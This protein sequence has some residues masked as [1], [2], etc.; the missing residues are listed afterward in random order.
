MGIKTAYTGY[1]AYDY[2]TPGEDYKY[3][4][5]T[6]K[7]RIPEYL[8]PLTP[9]QEERSLKLARE[10]IVISMHEH[11]IYNPVDLEEYRPYRHAGRQSF[12]Y[13]ALAESYLDCIFDN[14]MNGSCVITSHN[15]WK[16]TDIVHDLGMRLC[17]IA[18]Q[19]FV[20]HCKRVDDIHRA[21]K[22]GKLAWVAC[23]E[24]AMPIENEVDRIDIM[25]GL[26]IR[27]LGLTYSESNAVGSGLKEV[28][29][30][31]LTIFGREV[32]KRMNK[33]GMLI[34]VSHSSPLTAIDAAELS[35]VPICM[36]HAGAKA[37]WNSKRLATDESIKAIAA[38]GGVIGI[39]AAPH[40]TITNNH[41][42]HDI[43]AIMEHFEYVAN[44]VGID[45]VCFGPDTNFGDHAGLH[46]IFAKFLSTGYTKNQ[47][48]D[49]P[50]VDHVKGMEN[51]REASKNIIRWLV[52]HGY[53]DDDIGK[54]AGGNILRVL[55]KV[56]K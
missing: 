36:S 12:A 20:I 43:D 47:E 37:L 10:K 18:H 39:E 17:D 30:A 34:D 44:M 29:D 16:W 26:G 40:T 21:H 49:Y 14:M 13:E 32:V 3:F 27:L 42:V 5:L 11:P 24:G 31:G 1:K 28:R 46:R 41:R 33:V 54:V 23:I 53:S 35:E 22:E 8:V 4:E 38:G 51:P 56:W 19:D 48:D 2:L 7:D 9:E 45:H 55:G 25:Y 6:P 50:R 52:A 15:G